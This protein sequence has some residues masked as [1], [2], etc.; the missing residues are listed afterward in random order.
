MIESYDF[1]N[2]RVF[3]ETHHDDLKII[4]NKVIGNWWRRQGHILHTEDIAD[5]LEAPVEILVVGTGEYGNVK[6]P[7]EVAEAV[8]QRGI[9]F[10]ATPTREAV[11]TF[12]NLRAQGKRVAGAFHLTC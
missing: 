5:I 7:S 10:I 12:N 8:S 2:M 1:G 9:E 6:V 11:S 4:E 3:G